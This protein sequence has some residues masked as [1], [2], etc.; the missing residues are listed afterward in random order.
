[1]CGIV[2]YVGEKNCLKTIIDG[3]K[4]LEYRGYDSVGVAYFKDDDISIIKDKGRIMD[5][6]KK[7]DT[8]IKTKIGIGH[9]RWATHGEPSKVNAHPHRVNKITL[10]HNGII[11]NYD[12]I[13]TEL[14]K[15]GYEF[16]SDTD[17]EVLCAYIDYLYSKNNDMI[18]S[19]SMLKDK[20]KGSYATCI[21]CSDDKEHLYIVKKGSPLILGTSNDE[22]IIASDIAAIID[23]T[24]R[25]MIL[26]DDE[27]GIISG[28]GYEIC[29]SDLKVIKKDILTFDK[30]IDK[31]SKD[32]YDHFMLKEI[33]EED[34]LIKK[35]L[36]YYLNNDLL[37]D[38]P[39]LSKYKEIYIVGCGSAYNA[40]L[41]GK[42]YIEN[43]LN[44]PVYVEIASEF[45]YKKLF[46][47]DESLVIAISQSGE[48]ADTIEAVNIAK[49]YKAKTIGIVNTYKSTI[50]RISDEV[51]YINAGIEVA[52]ATTKAYSLQ[53]LYLILLS[54]RNKGID[55]NIINKISN[56]IKEVYEID[57]KELAKKISNKEHIFFIGRG[58]DYYLAIE[59]SLKLKEI[60]YI[61][62]EC[63]AAGE[64]KHGTI[65][66]IDKGTPV[67]S[68]ITNKDISSKTISNIKEVKARG[69][70][71]ILVCTDDIVVDKDI[72]DDIIIVPSD[73]VM[74][75]ILS[76]IGLQLLSYYVAKDKGCDIDK[77]RNLA[78][79]VTV[80]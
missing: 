29:D 34:D 54:L 21:L 49:K 2:G 27:I 13:R 43:Y 25:Y 57:Y 7:I 80:E 10:V 41:V 52:V 23:K 69:A 67:I 6:E 63:Y 77:P 30:N 46:I 24:K 11:E 9:T 56:D 48:T 66:L 35:T 59:G 55:K 42:Y 53:V 3:I 73:E 8:N 5:L 78:K 68:V 70:Y 60:S 58:I 51:I 76:I 72:Y 17:T 40:G 32:G 1:M 14:I 47:N 33:Y 20:I 50:A 79:S 71:V 12:E 45:R 74:S 44:I 64:L 4:A 31:I 61:H 37:K 39:D 19:L 22:Y 65:S 75:P 62:A 28:N 36:S 16:K 26:D 38:L 18:K 15:Y